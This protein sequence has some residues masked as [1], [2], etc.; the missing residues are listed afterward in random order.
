MRY[1]AVAVAA[2]RALERETYTYAV[3]AGLDVVPGHRVWVPVGS[4]RSL[5]YV[6]EVHT[7]E[8]GREVKE[9]ERA[10][11][12]PLLL[13]HQVEVA[14]AV[15]EHY[16]APL[17]DC[18]RAMLPPRVRSGRRSTGAGP[19]PRQTRHSRLLE[20]TL[21][22]GPPEPGP[23]LTP[24]QQRALETIRGGRPVLLHGVT[25]SGKTEV[26]MAAAAEVVAAGLRVL[27]LVPEIS[28]TPQLVERFSRRLGV[29]LAVL[30]SALT[31]LERGQQWWRVR[32]GEV[33]LVIGSRSAVFA[34][35]PRLGLICVDEEGSSAYKQ[36][37]V[38]RY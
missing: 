16:W 21:P 18:L 13:P 28:L 20:A 33:D 4:R 12:E 14:R 9:I 7:R 3:P 22:A 27:V 36:D 29:P 17:I 25:G 10:D 30:Y 6:T 15:A 31:E 23:E 38:P 11:P 19:S 26:Y 2:G 34:P 24:E 37:R 35:V 32:R 8:P 5:G 1:A